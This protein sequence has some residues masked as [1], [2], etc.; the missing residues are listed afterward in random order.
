MAN[1][2][3]YPINFTPKGLCDSID[4]TLSFQGACRSLQNLIFDQSN[5]EQV[6]ARPGVGTAITSFASFTAPTFITVMIGIGSYIYGMVSSGRNA[7]YD[8]PFCYLIGTGF[9]TISGVT[10]GNVPVSPSTTGDW[11]PPTMAVIGPN[12]IVTHP[13]FSGVGSNFFG[14]INIANPASPTWTSA[15]TATHT[16]PSVPTSVSNFNNRAYYACGNVMYYSD[17]LVPATM[18]NAGQALTLG[19]T[20][21]IIASSGLPVSTTSAGVVQALIVFKSFQIWQITGDAAISGSLSMN[22][23][24]LNVGCSSARTIVQTPVGTIFI[25]IDGPYVVSPLG[26]VLPLTKDA[27]K[28]V[29]DLQMPFQ[30][31]V[32]PTRACASYSGSIYRVCVDSVQSGVTGTYDYWFDVTVRRWSGPHTWPVDAVAQVGNYFVVS[33]RST[34]AALYKS[35]YLPDTTSVYNDNGTALTVVLESALFPKT[36]NINMKQV[37][38]STAELNSQASSLQYSISALDD[39]HSIIGNCSINAVATFSRWGGTGLTWGKPGLSWQSSVTQPS[40]YTLPW[41]SPLVFKKMALLIAASS[42]YSLAIGA[43]FAKYRDT[44]YTNK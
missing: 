2:K 36:P 44:G 8:E 17:S 26:A 5:P 14:I 15:N 31:I 9:I 22:Y 30:A 7:G 40:T 18:T 28:L 37:V 34:G 6:V 13:G 20:T 1:I 29:Q 39:Q 41:S 27:I 38:E 25:A 4:S 16:L 42:S 10:S 24:S 43:F 32:N 21:P 19:D 12:I 33:H 35:Q 23:L 3:E 11:I